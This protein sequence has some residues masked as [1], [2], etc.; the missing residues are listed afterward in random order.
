MAIM[1][2]AGRIAAMARSAVNRFRPHIQAEFAL[3]A[4]TRNSRN[5]FRI[6]SLQR[7]QK[8]MTAQFLTPLQKVECKTSCKFSEM[9]SASPTDIPN[10]GAFKHVL[11]SANSA[12]ILVDRRG[13][14]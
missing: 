7:F 3:N 6:D 1:T 10:A 9:G 11:C 8:A 2:R 5:S 4:M 13:Y 12:S 14:F